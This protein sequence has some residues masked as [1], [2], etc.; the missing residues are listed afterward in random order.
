MKKIIA[1]SSALA[2]VLGVAPAF[3]ANYVDISSAS[4]TEL[5]A[6]AGGLFSDLWVL[7]AIAIGVPLAFYIIKKVIGLIP[8]R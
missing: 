3:A 2:G 8:K 7:I 1:V 6:F 4:S 5:L